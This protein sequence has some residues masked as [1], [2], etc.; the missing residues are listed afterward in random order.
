MELNE[1]ISLRLWLWEGQALLELDW[2]PG[3]ALAAAGAKS[4]GPLLCLSTK[5]KRRALGR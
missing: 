4:G 2:D 1:L 5:I 3:V